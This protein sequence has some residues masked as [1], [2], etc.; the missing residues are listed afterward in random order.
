MKPIIAV[1]VNV[2]SMS[3]SETESFVER[4]L[5]RVKNEYV[6]TFIVP[7]QK[8]WDAQTRIECIYP[9][10]VVISNE[11]FEKEYEKTKEQL[12]QLTNALK[13]MTDNINLPGSTLYPSEPVR[14][15]NA[16]Q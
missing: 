13:Q 11:E 9:K 10:Y 12:T 7:I 14:D 5:A 8:P 15:F 6:T 3:E 2:G 16:D 4:T 1:Y